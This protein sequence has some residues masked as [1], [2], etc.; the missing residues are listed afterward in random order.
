MA[1]TGTLTVRD[2]CTQA[3][4]KARIGSIAESPPAENMAQAIAELN[5]MMKAWQNAEYLTFLYSSGSLTLTTATSYSLTPVVR[6]LRILS[7][8]LRRGSIDLPMESMTRGEYDNLPLKTST[9]TPTTF[10]YDKQTEDAEFYVWPALAAANGETIEYTFEREFE[11]VT[12]ANETLDLPGEWWEAAEYGLAARLM[13]TVPMRGQS[14]LVP[15]RAEMA[16]Q[17]ALAADHEGSVYFV[18]EYAG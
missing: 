4:R 8:R 7:A 5:Y 9:G 18:G 10:Y 6:P 14:P 15:Q 16:L 2:L 11:D 13:E 1:V 17:K 3:L 12:D